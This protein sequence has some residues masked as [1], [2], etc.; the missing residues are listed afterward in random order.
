MRALREGVAFSLRDC[1]GVI[2]EMKLPVKRIFLIG[3][4]ARSPLWSGI[5]CDVFHLP[6]CVPSPGDASFGAAL[7]A[8]TGVGVFADA[9]DAVGRCLKI[10]RELSPDPERAGKYAELFRTYREIHDALAPV[11]RKR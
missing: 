11:Y 8:G 10:D 5:V 4:G 9:R 3:G 1:Y 6:V 2:E 7:L